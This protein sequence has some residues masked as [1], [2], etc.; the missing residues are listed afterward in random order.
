[1]SCPGEGGNDSLSGESGA[2]LLFGGNGND[3][4]SGG[5][6]ND[7]LEGGVGHDSFAFAEGSGQD[8]ITDFA[9]GEDLIDVSGYTNIVFTNLV[10]NTTTDPGYTVIDLGQANGGEAG[11]DVVT[12]EDV[13]DLSSSDFLF[14]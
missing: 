13:I 6:G 10:L 8:T 9:R 11:I 12:V 2:D 4:L 3:N 14:A 5:S 1:M 7:T